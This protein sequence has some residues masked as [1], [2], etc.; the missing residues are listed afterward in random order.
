MKFWNEIRKECLSDTLQGAGGVGGL[1]Y[2]KRNGTIYVPH[3]DAYGNVMRYTDTAGNVVAE[4]TYDT[5]GK[6]IAQSGAMSEVFR[7]RF[8]TKYFDSESGLYYYGYRFYSPALMRWLN[9]DPIEEDGGLNMYGFCG[10]NSM[11][12]VDIVGMVE[13]NGKS[14]KKGFFYSFVV[15]KCEIAIIY[16]HG[17]KSFPHEISFEDDENSSAYFVGCLPDTTNKAIPDKNRLLDDLGPHRTVYDDETFKKLKEL[18]EHAMRRAKEIC[19]TGCCR[20][21][22]WIRYQISPSIGLVFAYWIGQREIRLETSLHNLLVEDVGKETFMS[23]VIKV[24][25]LSAAQVIMVVLLILVVIIINIASPFVSRAYAHIFCGQPIAPLTGFVINVLPTVL[26]FFMLVLLA[27]IIPRHLR[28][29]VVR[30]DLLSFLF[31]I[32]CGLY[33]CGLALPFVRY[34][35][36]LE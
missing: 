16:G 18:R 9:R 30:I 33:L 4:Y 29:R 3:C 34:H 15:K 14:D 17:H 2:L 32:I 21:G 6:T 20:N 25:E 36:G 1:L 35:I 22:V 27:L 31:V 23:N 8:S 13:Y 10:N 7:H 28:N 5:F 11:N 19:K 12:K 26:L 24:K